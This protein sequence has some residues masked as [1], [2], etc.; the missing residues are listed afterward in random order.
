MP[1]PDVSFFARTN[2]REPRRTFGIKQADRRHHCYLIGRTGTGK[3]TTIESLALQD[4]RDGRGVTVIDPHGDLAERLVAQVPNSRAADLSYLNAPDSEQPYGYN[5]LRG[6][7]PDKIPLA[8]SGLMESFKKL[9]DQ[10][11][12]VRMEHIL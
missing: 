8:A 7:R 12:G 4:M 5:P 2:G 3:T 1:S 10:A 11:W 9:W 6:V